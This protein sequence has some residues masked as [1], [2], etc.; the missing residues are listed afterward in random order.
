MVRWHQNS[1]R[2]VCCRGDPSVM[3]VVVA[4]SS[5]VQADKR[6]L[7]RPEPLLTHHTLSLTTQPQTHTH[8]H[9]NTHTQI[10]TQT[11]TTTHTH[12]RTQT[13]TH[14]HTHTNTHTHRLP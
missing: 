9:T 4:I 1:K 3:W 8:T 10:H 14:T 7:G 11:E 5:A 6:A 12:T 13:Q 2:D